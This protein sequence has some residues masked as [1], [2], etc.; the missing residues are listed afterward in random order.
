M[1]NI[2][3]HFALDG[4]FAGWQPHVLSETNAAHGAQLAQR[5]STQVL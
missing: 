2:L 4:L 3:D 5:A 1:P